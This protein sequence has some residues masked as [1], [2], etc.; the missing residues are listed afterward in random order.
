MIK[1]IVNDYMYIHYC[2]GRCK[3]VKRHD[4]QLYFSPKIKMNYTYTIKLCSINTQKTFLEH[5]SK[6]HW[7]NVQNKKNIHCRENDV[8]SWIYKNRAQETYLEF[9]SNFFL[10]IWNGAPFLCITQDSY[11]ECCSSSCEDVFNIFLR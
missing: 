1:I 6:K 5:H 11:L 10:R 8:E 3:N 4:L 7:Q 9:H 2:K